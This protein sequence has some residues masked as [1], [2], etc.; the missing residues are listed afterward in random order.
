MSSSHWSR[1]A[2]LH[3]SC[4]R[5]IAI[6]PSKGIDCMVPIGAVR[7]YRASCLSGGVEMGLT[8]RVH[9]WSAST[10]WPL[11]HV[12][13]RQAEYSSFSISMSQTWCRRRERDVQYIDCRR[14]QRQRLCP[15]AQCDHTTCIAWHQRLAPLISPK[16]GNFVS[17][18]RATWS[19]TM[20]C[21]C[22]DI[23]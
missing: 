4:K 12:E 8:S 1:R 10:R 11:I 5:T 9:T 13:E 22:K 14:S 6:A 7:R 17:R 15:L 2:V 16:Q 3:V 18:V 20:R 21:S 23:L 19:L